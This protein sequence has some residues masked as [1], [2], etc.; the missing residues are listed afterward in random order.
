M[1]TISHF[2]VLPLFP[3]KEWSRYWRNPAYHQF[4]VSMDSIQSLLQESGELSFQLHYPGGSMR[5]DFPTK[6]MCEGHFVEDCRQVWI[7][8]ATTSEK[9][10][11]GI[12]KSGATAD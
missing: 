5:R 1:A 6:G 4:E 11:V 2:P 3:Q 8:P 7:D 10:Y 9:L 12:C